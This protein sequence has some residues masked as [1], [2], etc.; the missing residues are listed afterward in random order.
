M[1]NIIHCY[2]SLT[3]KRNQA[4][5][6]QQVS[7]YLWPGRPLYFCHVVSSFFYLSFFYL[8]FSLPN[9]SRRRL[10]VYHIS[11][12]DVA[13][14]LKR[15][16]RGSLKIQDAKKS[17]KIPHLGTI[18]QRCRAISSQPRHISTIGKKL[19]KQQY[20]PRKFLIW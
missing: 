1:S 4:I 6:N 16:A 19:V 2:Q 12:H 18:G 13:L 15:A 5:R 14:G 20:F 11:T 3:T 17:P 9:L 8:L 10:D 7:L